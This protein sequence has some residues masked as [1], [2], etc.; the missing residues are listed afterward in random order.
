MTDGFSA[1][2]PVMQQA[3]TVFEQKHREVVQTL[4]GLTADLQSGLAKWEDD[5]RDAYFAAKAKWDEAADQQAKAIKE[6]SGVVRTARENYQSAEK[7]NAQMW[8]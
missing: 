4:D 1:D 6:F 7:T 8:T 5:A 3:Q 2:Y